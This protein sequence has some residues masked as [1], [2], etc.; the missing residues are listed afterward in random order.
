MVDIIRSTETYYEEQKMGE[1][2][3]IGMDADL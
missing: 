2:I 1:S 3:E